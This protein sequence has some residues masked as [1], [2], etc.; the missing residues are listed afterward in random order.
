MLK[1]DKSI[2]V[3]WVDQVLSQTPDNKCP[4]LVFRR[5]RTPFFYLMPF[6]DEVLQERC[7]LVRLRDRVWQIGLLSDLTKIPKE[8]MM[9]I[10]Q[11]GK[12]SI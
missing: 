9:Q 8:R 3:D 10:A 2:I 6:V 4:L 1:S 12:C 5:N 7:Y 11:K